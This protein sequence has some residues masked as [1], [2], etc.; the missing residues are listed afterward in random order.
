VVLIP[1]L[2]SRRPKTAEN[3]RDLIGPGFGQSIKTPVGEG[4][5]RAHLS[6]NATADRE[7]RTV[8]RE[9]AADGIHADRFS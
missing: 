6:P 1:I 8:I 5:A 3:I 7:T 9:L 2:L 4:A